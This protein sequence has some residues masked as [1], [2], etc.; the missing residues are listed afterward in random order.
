MLIRCFED[1]NDHTIHNFSLSIMV[2]FQFGAFFFTCRFIRTAGKKT[3]VL[4]V[5]NFMNNLKNTELLTFSYM[6][7]SFRSG[8]IT[9]STGNYRGMA[10]IMKKK[11]VKQT[12]RVQDINFAYLFLLFA[13]ISS[14]CLLLSFFFVHLAVFHIFFT[15]LLPMGLSRR[16]RVIE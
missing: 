13:G 2:L 4:K 8:F 1:A 7:R 3:H 15:G 5:T 12:S 16:P 11:T 14:F 6:F 10:H 9:V